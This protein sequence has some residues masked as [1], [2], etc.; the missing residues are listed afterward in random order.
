MRI[1]QSFW[2]AVKRPFA[3]IP[4]LIDAFL[5][6]QG[7]SHRSFHYYLED[8]DLTEVFRAVADG[9]RCQ[10]CDAFLSRCPQ[11]RAEAERY[12]QKGTACQRAIREYGLPGPIHTQEINQCTVQSLHNFASS[13]NAEKEWFCGLLPKLY[14]R[15]H[16]NEIR[17]IYRDI[18]FF[19]QQASSPAPVV[20]VPKQ[21]YF[22]S[23]ITILRNGLPAANG[24][25]LTLV[26]DDPSNVPDA[27]AY[28]EALKQH[29][30]CKEYQASVKFLLSEQEI[31]LYEDLNRRAAP[32]V[33]EV[34]DFFDRRMPNQT[35]PN[36]EASLRQFASQLKKL[37]AQYGYTYGGY[38][39]FVYTLEKKLP[40]GHYI[41]LE[42]V[43]HP[44]F[45]CADPCIELCGLGFRHEI[46]K[47]SFAP[48][49]SKDTTAYLSRFF[50][51]L[52]EA[53][54]TLLPAIADLYPDTPHWFVPA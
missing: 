18:D 9:R 10:E 13:D 1:L 16:F 28:A 29:L 35:Q 30:N 33:Q 24:V 49:N 54:Q 23:G 38:Q 4:P 27:S 26:S 31:A 37:G 48:V 36:E 46:W 42:F 40:N 34:S 50:E 14:R 22:C 8:Y 47:G 7:L 41:A 2:Y 32:F 19:S 21:P 44:R 25:A 51:T 6:N 11:C 52:E 43:S 45:P 20:T 39:Y 15:C 17:L 12:L 5:R 53:E 3:Q